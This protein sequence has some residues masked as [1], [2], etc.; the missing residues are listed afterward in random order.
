MSKQPILRFQLSTADRADE[1]PFLR[2]GLRVVHE[3]ALCVKC[4]GAKL[5]LERRPGVGLDMLVD[6]RLL[7]KLFLAH[8][9]GVRAP[10]GVGL[11]M[12][13][14]MVGK[15]EGFQAVRA[16]ERPF[17]QFVLTNVLKEFPPRFE[18]LL[19]AGGAFCPW[20]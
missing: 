10:P 19:S 2:V 11:H 5:A 4:P 14:Q 16:V 13:A 1:K 20:R 18:V 6:V 7:H 9:A 3:V 8:P 12:V 17:F 15:L